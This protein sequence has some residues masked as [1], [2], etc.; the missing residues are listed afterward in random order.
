MAFALITGS[1]VA[2]AQADSDT[3]AVSATVIS[4]CNVDASDLPFG[5]YDPVSAGPLDAATTVDVTCT[6]GTS[7][8]VALDEG[9]G[10]G[11]TVAVRRMTGGADVLQY[12]LYRNAGRTNVW[13]ETAGIDTVAGTGTGLAQTLNVYGRAPANQ[14][15]PA[16]SFSDTV[17]VTVTY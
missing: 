12:S 6:S 5:D 11:A 4:S 15:A 17:T 1:S 16:G 7:Y 8:V 3:I 9:L 10:A 13:G 2:Q 14:T